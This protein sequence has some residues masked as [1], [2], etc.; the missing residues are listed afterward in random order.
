MFDYHGWSNFIG[1][2]CD[3]FPYLTKQSFAN[4]GFTVSE[5]AISLVKGKDL[6]LFVTSLNNMALSPNSGIEDGEWVKKGVATP[7]QEIQ[8]EE[9]SEKEAEEEDPKDV[10]RTPDIP[11][12]P[13]V[14]HASTLVPSGSHE[15]RLAL[16]KASIKDLK[17]HMT[18]IHEDMKTMF[19]EIKALLT[20][21][22][23][24]LQILECKVRS[25]HHCYNN[26]MSYCLEVMWKWRDTFIAKVDELTKASDGLGTSIHRTVEDISQTCDIFIY[27]DRYLHPN[28]VN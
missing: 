18:I 4:V 8:E 5:D 6:D 22:S 10:P 14:R 12:T 21:H 7:S 23:S 15:T 16:M 17:D 9:A 11:R 25:P 24:K 2:K 13:A 26:N 1:L 20:S 3:S 19:D 28:V 27:T